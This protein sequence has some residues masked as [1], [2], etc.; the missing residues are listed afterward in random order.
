MQVKGVPVK[1]SLTVM[2]K[3]SDQDY[4]SFGVNVSLEVELAPDANLDDVFDSMDAYLTTKVGRS[5]KEKEALLEKSQVST[6]KQPQGLTQEQVAWFGSQPPPPNTEAWS[7]PQLQLQFTSNGQRY[8]NVKGGK[9][10]K[11]GAPAWPENVNLDV[12]WKEWNPEQIYNL[13]DGY[14]EA[15]V[16]MKEDGKPDKVISFR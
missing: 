2:R 10:M 4:G 5:M 13:P 6:K 11:Y 16:Q 14:S 8:L 12:E 1:A 15:L 9:W 7:N 3:L